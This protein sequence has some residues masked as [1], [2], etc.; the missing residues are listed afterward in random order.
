M[1]TR[2][3]IKRRPRRQVDVSGAREAL[4]D[5]RRWTAFGVVVSRDGEPHF[6]VTEGDAGAD[7]LVEVDLQPDELPVTCRLAAAAGGPG[8]GVWRVPPV[9]SEVVVVIPDGELEAG[10]IIV[11]V[12]SSGE[13]PDGTGDAQIVI[14]AP[15]V[16]VYD[17]DSGEAQPLP[18]LAE[19]R[20]HT[21]MTG[22]GESAPTTDPVI[23]VGP[24]EGTKVLKAK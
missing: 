8:N 5:V 14:V 9:G 10:A 21:H 2:S 6:E 18:T 20:S 23:G 3:K 4:E 1:R 7:V 11:G 16:L 13:V 15:Q 24:I 22:M 12:L 17:V 19:F